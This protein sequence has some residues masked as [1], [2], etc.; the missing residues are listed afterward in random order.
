M[1]IYQEII[2]HLW[3][4][5]LRLSRMKHVVKLCYVKVLKNTEDYY[6]LVIL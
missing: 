2:V 3:K 6:T 4:Y 5:R 1:S